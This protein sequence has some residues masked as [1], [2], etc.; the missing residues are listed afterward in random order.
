M[1]WPKLVDSK[2][3][4]N[5]SLRSPC[6]RVTQIPSP[7]GGEPEPGVTPGPSLVVLERGY[8]AEPVRSWA[9]LH[10]LWPGNGVPGDT[11]NRGP[12]QEGNAVSLG[13]PGRGRQNCPPRGERRQVR[14]SAGAG[15][16]RLCVSE[17]CVEGTATP[18]LRRE[19]T[20]S[21]NRFSRSS[22]G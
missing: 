21:R 13:L 19:R 3:R 12:T 5:E 20:I 1:N 17:R 7:G 15:G 11:P 10:S 4:E 9:R 14:M 18:H 8:W 16:S 22:A 2:G 6:T